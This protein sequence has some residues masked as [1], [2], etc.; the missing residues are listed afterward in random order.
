MTPDQCTVVASTVPVLLL[1]YVLEAI[2]LLKTES[3]SRRLDFRWF[4]AGAIVLSFGCEML[5][6]EGIDGGLSGESAYLTLSLY[7]SLWGLL[8]GLLLG[9][10]LPFG[11]KARGSGAKADQADRE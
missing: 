7:Y 8:V 4:T 11:L 5:S 2:G 3:D 6:F 10:V 1:A 9:L